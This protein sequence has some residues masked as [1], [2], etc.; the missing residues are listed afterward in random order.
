MKK[1]IQTYNWCDWKFAYHRRDSLSVLLVWICG[2]RT[3]E[4]M[5]SY[6]LILWSWNLVYISAKHYK[7]RMWIFFGNTWEKKSLRMWNLTWFSNLHFLFL[8]LQRKEIHPGRNCRAAAR[9]RSST[10]L[11]FVLISS[12]DS[13]CHSIVFSFHLRIVTN[14][15]KNSCWIYRQWVWTI[16]CLDRDNR[17]KLGYVTYIISSCFRWWKYKTH[18]IKSQITDFIERLVL[19]HHNPN[20]YWLNCPLPFSGPWWGAPP[21]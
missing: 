15:F 17:R 11:E 20:F 6:F 14:I 3:Y 19:L 10:G 18:I 9:K 4:W 21:P 16:G 8:F 7:S 13:V 2:H 12:K 5:L 1:Y